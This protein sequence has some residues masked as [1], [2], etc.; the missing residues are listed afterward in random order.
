MAP[1]RTDISASS[2]RVAGKTDVY[3]DNLDCDVLIVGAGFAGVY[4]LHRLR[5]ELGLNVKV[6]E[7]G[8]N[9]GGIWHWNCYPGTPSRIYFESD[10][11]DRLRRRSRGHTNPL[12]RVLLPFYLEGK[13]YSLSYCFSVALTLAL[14]MDMDR[15]VSRLEGTS[16][17]LQVRGQ[18][19]RYQQG[20][21][22]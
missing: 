20:R 16:G 7:A 6:Y 8:T 12:L 17:V 15:K 1:L 10:T 22:I 19:A 4:L 2:P 5:D 11:A 3:K 13:P 18:E 9:L 21:C 14:G